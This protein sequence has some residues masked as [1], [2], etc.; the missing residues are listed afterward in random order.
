MF[1]FDQYGNL[2]KMKKTFSN[3]VILSYNYN[4]DDNWIIAD[5]V[6]KQI[7]LYLY[8][9]FDSKEDGRPC[10]KLYTDHYK[11]VYKAIQSD[12]DVYEWF[13]DLVKIND[14]YKTFV[15]GI[16]ASPSLN[17][18]MIFGF[19]TPQKA[20][21]NPSNV[22]S[23]EVY[24]YG[25]KIINSNGDI[26]SYGTYDPFVKKAF[27]EY[28]VSFNKEKKEKTQILY[29]NGHVFKGEAK[30]VM[31]DDSNITKDRTS[32]FGI[33]VCDYMAG[34]ERCI[35]YTIDDVEAVV[36]VNGNVFD[37]NDKVLDIYKDGQLLDDFDKM[38][39]L[40]QEQGKID[41]E[42]KAIADAIAKKDAIYKY[43]GAAN[44]D[45]FYAGELIIGMPED[46][47]LNGVKGH[48][49]KK[50]WIANKSII[51]GSDVCYDLYKFDIAN[52]TFEQVGY[53]WVGLKNGK[54]VITSIVY[55]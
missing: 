41:R 8:Q 9:P 31:K 26:F 50:F 21:F 17:E 4:S 12:P 28:S 51:D 23:L 20:V 48:V 32:E 18:T 34:R 46:L 24:Y 54:K 11:L 7:R 52:P 1:D 47:F 37:V 3:G 29:Q 13:H 38:S 27:A 44:A 45:A 6:T 42:K 15:N 39:L 16:D 14:W 22:K 5:Y 43:Y 36:P 55:Y 35:P 10:R 2:S 49:F 25:Y 40:A 30:L 53:I 33:D 19:H